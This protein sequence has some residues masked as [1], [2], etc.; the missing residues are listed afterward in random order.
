MPALLHI[1]GLVK[2]FEAAAAALGPVDLVLEAG[3]IAAIIGRSGTGKS[4]LLRVLAGLERPE[5]GKVLFDGRPIRP[6]DV[7]V[8]FQEPRLMPW[9]DVAGNVGFG[10]HSL[11]KPEREAAVA[12]A[13]DVVGLTAHAGKWPKQLSGGMAQRVALARALAVRPRLLLL[14]EPFSALDP[15]TRVAMQEHLLALWRHYGPTIIL[16]SHDMDEA[17]ALADHI[18]VLDGPPG[19]VVAEFAP[20]LPHPR[21]RAGPGFQRWHHRLVEMLGTSAGKA[22]ARSVAREENYAS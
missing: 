11:L 13:L 17:L 22:G 16:I 15:L 12:E 6:E 7:G 2:R 14:D 10:L 18:V 19:R 5:S 3:R 21:R 9:L 4:T 1:G 20:D 8:V